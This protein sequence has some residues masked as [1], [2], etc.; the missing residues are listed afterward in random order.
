MKPRDLGRHVCVVLLATMTDAE[1][2][3]VERPAPGAAPSAF[4]I[5]AA[6]ANETD[7]G[8]VLFTPASAEALM[9]E[10]EQRGRL[11]PFDFDHLSVLPD[12]PATAGRAAGWHRLAVRES[13]DGPE[14]WAVDIEWCEDTRAGLE[15]RP[16]LWRYFSPAFRT[17]DGEVT[18]YINCAVCINPLT[19]QLPSLASESAA[20]GTTMKEKMLAA[21]ATLADS[22]ATEEAKKEAY[23]ALADFFE[24]T[25]EEDKKT[26]EGPPPPP[27]P[28]E[29]PKDQP[30]KGEKIDAEKCADADGDNDGDEK[31]ETKALTSIERRLGAYDAL[32]KR[33][34]KMDADERARLLAARPDLTAGMRKELSTKPLDEV[35]RLLGFMPAP[36]AKTNSRTTQG[37]GDVDGNGAVG[38]LQGAELEEYNRLAGKRAPM[39]KAYER[40]ADG[41]LQLN[42]V[43]PTEFRAL[44]ARKEGK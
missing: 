23:K 6:G 44:T 39:T 32:V 5:W 27:P 19:H 15:A 29:S 26:S 31:T 18:S 33:A 2:P 25:K 13:D 20:K 10:Q 28:A 43:T 1:S 17:K 22:N 4:R 40:R 35:V 41:T 37:E 7:T 24:E 9:A 12:R 42:A 30:K 3:H 38:G 11:Y 21:L 14:L 8:T 34:E 16:P 36:A